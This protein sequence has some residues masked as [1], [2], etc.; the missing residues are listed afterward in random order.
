[1]SRY[2]GQCDLVRRKGA[3]NEAKWHAMMGC[4]TPSTFAALLRA[5]DISPL[6]DEDETPREFLAELR[7]ADPDAGVFRSFWGDA[8]CWFL[9][10]AGFEYIFVED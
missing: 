3:S 1:M 8:P 4:A 5:V 6:L 7:R 9:Q 10:T 2:V